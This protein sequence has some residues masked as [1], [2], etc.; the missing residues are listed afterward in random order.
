MWR[1]LYFFELVEIDVDVV[2]F[3]RCHG[4][5]RRKYISGRDE[6][7]GNKEV[8][9]GGHG[10]LKADVVSVAIAEVIDGESG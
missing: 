10:W 6:N 5:T 3:R 4:D 1:R 8:T 2:A 9:R 7:R